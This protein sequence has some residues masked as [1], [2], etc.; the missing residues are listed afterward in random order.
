MAARYLQDA[1]SVRRV[2][3]A[4]RELRPRR[5]VPA[6]PGAPFRRGLPKNAVGGHSGAQPSLAQ[7]SSGGLVS[8]LH[9]S[10]LE[11]LGSEANQ[12]FDFLGLDGLARIRVFPTRLLRLLVD[13]VI[14]GAL[15][16]LSL[17]VPLETGEEARHG[18]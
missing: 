5:C 6:F 10:R 3:V 16:G 8:I 11:F 12:F 4:Q 17:A 2:K 13:Q 9:T 1:V 18:F 14:E 7:H 15:L